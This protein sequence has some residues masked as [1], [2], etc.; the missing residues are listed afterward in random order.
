MAARLLLIAAALFLLAW[1]CV[2]FA[3]SPPLYPG[4]HCYQKISRSD[5]SLAW[6][7]SVP[8]ALKMNVPGGGD[9]ERRRLKR[10]AE[11][12]RKIQILKTAGKIAKGD[13]STAAVKSEK[14]LEKIEDSSAKL[15]YAEKLAE[16]FK[17]REK[18]K[19]EDKKSD[20]DDAEIVEKVAARLRAQKSTINPR[21][22]RT[23]GIGGAWTPPTSTSNDNNNTAP[24][25]DYKPARGSW[26]VFERPRDISSAYGGGKRVGAGVNSTPEEEARAAAETEETLNRLKRYREKMGQTNRLEKKESKKIQD[27]LE[28][29]RRGMMKGVYMVAVNA[30]EDVVEYCSTSSEVGGTVFLELGMA[31]EAA[32]MRAEAKTVYG[33]LAQSGRG[34]VKSNARRLLFNSEAMAFMQDENLGVSTTK[35]SK[36]ANFIDTSVLSRMSDFDDK[37]YSTAYVDT[38][39]R[40][41][42][43]SLL[44]D[45]AAIVVQSS[46]EAKAVIIKAEL[47]QIERVKFVRA[48]LK[49]GQEYD[50]M[51]AG[52]EEK[53]TATSKVPL[54]N[55]IPIRSSDRSTTQE[56]RER[57]NG[58]IVYGVKREEIEGEWRL[59]ACSSGKGEEVTFFDKT[60]TNVPWSRVENDEWKYNIPSRGWGFGADLGGGTY[61]SEWTGRKRLVKIEEDRAA[62]DFIRG[63]SPLS[64]FDVLCCDQEILITRSVAEGP[65]KIM[66]WRRVSVGEISEKKARLKE[67]AQQLN[68]RSS[69]DQNQN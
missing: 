4:P 68:E 42:L 17:E 65:S 18:D 37:S 46:A 13:N 30:L 61:F 45:G 14:L 50:E 29:A 53:K 49:I 9:S 22:P 38:S 36:Q 20:D 2:Q 7:P 33:Q 1:P 40:G 39:S 63:Q 19:E 58:N 35:E 55:G 44:K 21:N 62:W 43:S 60:N 23:S 32:G 52:A 66:A 64:N 48:L 3:P 69:D 5:R 57:A 51:L 56:D 26:G 41:R 28:M 10:E 6:R 11:I 12:R 47:E 27:A 54:I 34:S 15:D 31:Y 67:M 24:E 16:K 59:Q 25:A 8:S